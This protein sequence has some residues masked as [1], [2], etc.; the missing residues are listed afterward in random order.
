MTMLKNQLRP[1]IV[2]S[3]L[4]CL[5]TG[6]VYPGIVTAVAQL[7][8]PRQA[9]GSLVTGP[10]GPE[11]G[12]PGLLAQNRARSAVPLPRSECASNSSAWRWIAPRP[13]PDVPRV[14]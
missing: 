7:L 4:L 8:F 1:A 6:L 12:G 5:I 2:L 3:L 10:R 14:E 11:A 13:L 9:N